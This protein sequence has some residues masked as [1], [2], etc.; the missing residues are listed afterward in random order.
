[1]AGMK[2]IEMPIGGIPSSHF[3][4][5]GGDRDVEGEPFYCIVEHTVQRLFDDALW[6]SAKQNG[7]ID[8]WSSDWALLFL[9]GGIIVLLFAYSKWIRWF[10]AATRHQANVP[11]YE[12]Q[13]PVYD[14]AITANEAPYEAIRRNNIVQSEYPQYQTV[15]EPA[16]GGNVVDN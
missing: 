10:F 6:N 1:M 12:Q 2:P 4:A 3:N 11:G 5:D 9:V 13:S 14:A 16:Y 8:H 7:G 15:Q